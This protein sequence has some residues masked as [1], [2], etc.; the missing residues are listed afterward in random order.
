MEVIRRKTA[1]LIQGACQ[2]GAVFA[3]APADR[4]NALAEYGLSLGIAFQMADDLL[5]FIADTKTLGKEIGADLREGKL[6]LPVIHALGR[7]SA[8]DRERIIAGLAA[9]D[10]SRENIRE[11]VDLLRHYGSI[12][13]TE[14][15]AAK[16]VEKAKSAISGFEPSQTHDILLDI[17]DYVLYRE[18]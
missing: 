1:V 2:I 12:A 10:L 16:Y 8:T 3:D 17:A 11:I 4:E 9:K 5:D 6:T 7:A 18:K 14:T 15:M 13:Y